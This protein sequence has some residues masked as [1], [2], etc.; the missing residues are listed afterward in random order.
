VE[1]E[2]LKGQNKAR[3][4]IAIALGGAWAVYLGYRVCRFLKIIPV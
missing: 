4:I 2:A 1:N 3:L